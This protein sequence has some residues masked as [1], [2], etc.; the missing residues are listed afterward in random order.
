MS[1]VPSTNAKLV[2]EDGRI[3]TAWR[4]AFARALA[5]AEAGMVV[6][7]PGATVGTEVPNGW[8]LCNN[9]LYDIKLYKPLFNV[10]GNQFGGDGTTTFAAPPSNYLGTAPSMIKT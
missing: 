3:T 7:W 10:I 1:Y 2:D 6:A 5:G 8:L 9:A 4:S